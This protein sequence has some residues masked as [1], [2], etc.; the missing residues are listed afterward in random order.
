VEEEAAEDAVSTRERTRV[1]G[2]TILARMVVVK[3][4]REVPVEA[5]AGCRVWGPLAEQAGRQVPL[6]VF[7][8]CRA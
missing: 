3:A 7:A 8:G 4:V 5:F 6:E 2:G 1:S